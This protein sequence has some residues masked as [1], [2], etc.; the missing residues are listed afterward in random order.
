M[1]NYTQNEWRRCETTLKT[2]GEDVKLHS[3]RVEKMWNYT[4]NEWRRRENTLKTSGEDVKLHSK[5]VEK[6]WNY[7]RND[8]S[9]RKIT[10]ETSGE[11]VK[12]HS[13][14]VGKLM[15]DLP[16]AT[17]QRRL[18]MINWRP[19]WRNLENWSTLKWSERPRV[20][21][22]V[23]IFSRKNHTKKPKIVL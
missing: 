5:R 19:Y 17:F 2:S 6:M 4:R 10:L 23:L 15:L 22:L 3:K 8:W 12:L 20:G 11:D 18:V 21:K 7:T 13:K 14:R 9:G 1:W 16:L